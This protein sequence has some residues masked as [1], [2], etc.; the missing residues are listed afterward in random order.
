MKRLNQL[1]FVARLLYA[2]LFRARRG[3]WWESPAQELIARIARYCYARPH[4]VRHRRWLFRSSSFLKYR[5]FLHADKMNFV[6]RAPGP[7]DDRTRTGLLYWQQN[8][9]ATN[10]EVPETLAVHGTI[11]IGDDE[12]ASMNLM[13][14]LLSSGNFRNIS[15]VWEN[16]DPAFDVR[17]L[18]TGPETDRWNEGAE[19]FDLA[20]DQPAGIEALNKS[21]LGY[22]VSAI[23]PDAHRQN[24]QLLKTINPNALVVAVSLPTDDLGF[25]D[26][27]LR[28]NLDMFAR[29]KAAHPSVLFCVLNPTMIEREHADLLGDTGVL[30]VRTRGNNELD[31]VAFAAKA[32]LF[33]GAM[34]RF[35]LVALTTGR[36]GLYTGSAADNIDAAQTRRWF[37]SAPGE[38]EIETIL[39]Q[40]ISEAAQPDPAAQPAAVTDI[41]SGTPA[42]K[43]RVANSKWFVEEAKRAEVTLYIDVFGHCNLRC[44][45]C[46]VGNFGTDDPKSFRAGLMDQSTLEAILEKGLAETNVTSV[47]L[48]NW[49]EPLLNPD[50]PK[51]IRTVKSYG[52]FCS[53]STNLNVLRDPESLLDSNLDWLRI[54]VSGFNQEVYERGHKGGDVTKVRENM[55]RLAE[56]RTKVGSK[57]DIE[58][59]FHKYRDNEE[60]EEL[61]RAYAEELGFRFVSAWAYLMPVE[62]MLKISKEGGSANSLSADDR[63][64]VDRLALSPDKALDVTRDHKIDRCNLYDYLTIDVRGDIYLCCASSG[65]PTNKLGNYLELPI[66]KIRELQYSHNLCGDCIKYG[67]PDL[68]GHTD[69]AFDEI[70]QSGRSS[71]KRESGAEM[72]DTVTA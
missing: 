8:I 57:T 62:K 56:A 61:M 16:A 23:P 46:P 22:F 17:A 66:E 70:G 44:P 11:L 7:L 40:L 29:L 30:T 1:M 19:I 39:D 45:S 72:P 33:F 43:A 52:L 48:F 32:D 24:N 2:S 35:A 3:S 15:L 4:S 54:S 53:I 50:L 18:L 69:P 6:A 20:N 64:L 58:V 26:A 71:W 68:Y 12:F 55:K 49:T 21:G 41:P 65:A 47:G 9:R 34:D 51:L 13:P 14:N 31:A 36:P 42:W 37:R 5:E 27:A 63:E 59:F 60:D 25:C 38:A 10:P 67:L 28:Q